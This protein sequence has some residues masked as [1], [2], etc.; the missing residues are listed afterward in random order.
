LT[1]HHETT[2]ADF[3]QGSFAHLFSHEDVQHVSNVTVRNSHGARHLP[4]V[5]RPAGQRAE[6]LHD[7]GEIATGS[8]Q[9]LTASSRYIHAGF[10]AGPASRRS[11]FAIW[12]LSATGLFL[13][14]SFALTSHGLASF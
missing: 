3:H 7:I 8:A 1:W 10:F 4:R 12:A 5:E 2:T 14:L 6:N 13:P 11:T 9:P